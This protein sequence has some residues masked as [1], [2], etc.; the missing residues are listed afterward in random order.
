MGRRHRL[1][2]K[3]KVRCI[4]ILRQKD[5]KRQFIK[6][7]LVGAATTGLDFV[8]F[9]SLAHLGLDLQLANLISVSASVLLGFIAN[10]VF[11]FADR[12]PRWQVALVRF[13]ALNLAT[14]VFHLGAAH[15]ALSVAGTDSLLEANGIKLAVVVALLLIRFWIS[16]TFI[17]V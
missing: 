8:L 5:G 13:M 3:K 10:L 7:A 6:F 15:V 14:A 1:C 17:F 11:T 16:R 4:A 12:T 2:L 9:N